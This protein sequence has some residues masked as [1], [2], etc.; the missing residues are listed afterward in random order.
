MTI[1][2]K[3]LS[4][5]TRKVPGSEKRSEVFAKCTTLQCIQ[6]CFAVL[7]VHSYHGVLDVNNLAEREISG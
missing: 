1:F 2:E 6:M 3:L 5:I 7:Q 4:V